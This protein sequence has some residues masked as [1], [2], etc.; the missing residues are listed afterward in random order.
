MATSDTEM[1]DATSSQLSEL[2]STQFPDFSRTGSPDSAVTA[3]STPSGRGSKKRTQT[4]IE[5]WAHAKKLKLD[6]QVRRDRAGNRIW[7]CGKCSWESAS[8]TSARNHLDQTHGIKIKSQQLQVVVKDQAKLHLMAWHAFD[9]YYLLTDQ[10]PAYAAAL[11]LHPSRRKRYINVNW[12]KSWVRAVLP[13]LQSLWEE[14]Y[15]IIKEAT[16]LTLS[17]PTHEPDEYDLLE[18]DLNVVQTFAD[19]WESFIEAD[20]TEISTKTALEWWCQEQQRIRYPRLSRMAIDLLSVPAMSAEAERV[21]SGA[22]RQIPW[23][24]ANLGAK[25]IEQME[26]LKHWLRK[27]WLNQLNVDLPPEEGECEGEAEAE[28]SGSKVSCQS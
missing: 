11:L 7:V 18:R 10:V 5:T 6:E 24:R 16:A 26:C 13:K 25:T 20:P 27:G 28:C 15:A 14:K 8:L 4:A 9:K 17:Q 21:F 1:N 12:K 2:D 3:V 19:D 23:S 22:R